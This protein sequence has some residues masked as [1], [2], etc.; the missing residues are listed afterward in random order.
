MGK[1]MILRKKV[2]SRQ[3]KVSH[4]ETRGATRYTLALTYRDRSVFYFVTTKICAK[5]ESNPRHS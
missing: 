3:S 2:S 4:G 1:M 5:G